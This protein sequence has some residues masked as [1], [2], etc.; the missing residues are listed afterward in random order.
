MHESSMWLSSRASVRIH[1]MVAITLGAAVCA[2]LGGLTAPA[3]AGATGITPEV[4]QPVSVSALPSGEVE[5]VLSGIPLKDLSTTQ[6]GEVLSQLPGLSALSGE[7]LRHALTN[8]IEGLE[9]SN[10]TLGQLLSSHEL[11]SNLEGQLKH[12][13]SLSELTKLE[14]P[15]L[16]KGQNLSG[17]LTEALGSVGARQVLGGLL[18]STGDPSQLIEQVLATPS[19][20]KL[21]ALLGSTLAG[22]P[23]TTGTVE[24]LASEAGTTS[25]GLAKDLDTTASQ[26]P[27]SAMA[28][29][30]PL[31]DGK[32]LGVL[33]AL[34]GLDLGLLGSAPEGSGGGS[35][36]SGGG[37][38]GGS[39]GSGSGSSG[40][41]GGS[42]GSSGI[43]GGSTIVVDNLP[44]QG[45][46]TPNSGAKA[47]LA[48]V[49]ILSRKVKGNAVTLVVQTPAAGR[50][51][52][53]GKS[54]RS[55][56]EQTDK[57]ERV[58]LR[59]VLTKAGVASL[60]KH[61]H[62][63]KVKLDVSFE[64]VSGASSAAT[65]TVAFG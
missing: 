13:L 6:L 60:R 11:V 14:L 45:A 27:A 48:K 18:A 51:T 24:E 29:T 36:G 49:K 56:S 44:A 39:G 37:G 40:G 41:S 2:L 55:V 5:E 19:P 53:K 33:D 61:D 10:G 50:V 15:L 7:S 20:E 1:R 12:L 9:G 8:T 46:S 31:T 38:S 25:E 42:G 3:T 21:Q 17:V 43:P 34:E 23:F 28:L 57:A 65:T 64:R 30:A 59:T 32:T 26:L 58:T 63:L 4:T 16:L 62:R 54:L 47:S 52:V 22:T 35:G